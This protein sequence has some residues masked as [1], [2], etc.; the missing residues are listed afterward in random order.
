VSGGDVFCRQPISRPAQRV[1][2]RVMAPIDKRYPRVT[3]VSSRRS[4]SVPLSAC[5]LS[6]SGAA[7]LA[8]NP[9]AALACTPIVPLFDQRFSS[10]DVSTGELCAHG[11]KGAPAVRPRGILVCGRSKRARTADAR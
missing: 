5:S 9:P 3:V 1:D 11:F 2:W 10:P 7:K 4:C 6:R 8:V